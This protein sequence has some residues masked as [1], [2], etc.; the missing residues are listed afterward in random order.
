MAA[1]GTDIQ[2]ETVEFTLQ[3]QMSGADYDILFPEIAGAVDL[4]SISAGSVNTGEFG[5][6]T[7][8]AITTDNQAFTLFS[9]S[10]GSPFFATNPLV[11]YTGNNFTD[12]PVPTNIKGIRIDSSG[13][14]N[15]SA[16]LTL[17]TG[18]VFTFSVVPEPA[19]V[20]L[21][22]CGLLLLAAQRKG[23]FQRPVSER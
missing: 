15:Q 1:T 10:F 13:A 5:S 11:T 19:A 3:S 2:A 8:S 18:T 22:F 14:P 16:T 4:V 12:F 7:I 20:M 23:M 9:R 17:P 21:I 6:M